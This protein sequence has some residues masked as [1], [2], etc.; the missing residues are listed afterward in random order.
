M[1]WLQIS[2]KK[3]YEVNM[4]ESRKFKESISNT[5]CLDVDEGS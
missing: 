3:D 2:R 5:K 4:C 1:Q